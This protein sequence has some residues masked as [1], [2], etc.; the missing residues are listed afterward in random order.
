[1]SWMPHVT[2]ATV[3]ERDGRF[4]LVEETNPSTT[5]LVLNQPAGHVEAGETLMQAAVRE[6]LEETGWTVELTGLLGLYTYTP[7]SAPD[8]TYYRVCYLAHALSHDPHYQLDDGIVRALWMTRE[9]LEATGRM[10]SP[11]VLRC[12]DDAQAGRCF[13]LDLVYEQPLFVADPSVSLV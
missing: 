9:E 10:R 4:L 1:M 2:V 6:T 3:I 8:R 13:P 5:H 12:I 11:L 7:P